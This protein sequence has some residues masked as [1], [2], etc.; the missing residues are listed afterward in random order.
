MEIVAELLF[1]TRLE[2]V[3]PRRLKG[4]DR[5]VLN[6]PVIPMMWEQPSS[7]PYT[8][9]SIIDRWSPFNQRDTSIA[10]MRNLYPINHRIPI[11]VLSEE[12]FVPFL[13]YLDKM[14]YQCMAEDGMHMRNH[15]FN[16]KAELVYSN[17]IFFFLNANSCCHFFVLMPHLL[18]TVTTIQNM[19]C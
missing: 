13:C 19:A 1:L 14:S 10:H 4:P 12:Y 9:Q 8:A 11:M 18:Q 7:G 15:D 2:N 3:G 5:L 17:L 16:E 6:S